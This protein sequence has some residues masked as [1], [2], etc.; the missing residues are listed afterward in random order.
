MR[1]KLYATTGLPISV[2]FGSILNSRTEKIHRIGKVRSVRLDVDRINYGEDPIDPILKVRPKVRFS[3]SLMG[4]CNRTHPIPATQSDR[5]SG[6]FY[7][8]RDGKC[9]AI[10]HGQRLDGS[11]GEGTAKFLNRLVDEIMIMLQL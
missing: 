5:I 8:A 7:Q 6:L 10:F 1:V 9:A 3:I 2:L 11:D 4:L